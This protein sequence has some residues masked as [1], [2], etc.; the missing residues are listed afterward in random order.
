MKISRIKSWYGALILIITAVH[1]GGPTSVSSKR[2]VP[3][4]SVNS[5]FNNSN[6]EAKANAK[7]QQDPQLSLAPAAT[8]GYTESIKPYLD[9]TCV[10]CHRTGGLP[11]DLSSYSTAKAAAAVSLA[12]MN[13]GTM[14]P[15]S[16][17][18]ATTLEKATFAAWIAGGTPESIPTTQ[19]GTTK[20]PVPQS[21]AATATVCKTIVTS[22]SQAAGT[23]ASGV[24]TTNNSG[25]SPEPAPAPA[26]AKPAITYTANIKPYFDARCAGCHGRA[27]ALRTYANVQ[28]GAAASLAAMKRGSMPPGGGAPAQDIANLQ[29]WINAGYPQ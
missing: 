2:T 24:P 4:D 29:A 22:P 20:S 19:S 1:C 5:D 9:D 26:P 12:S 10:G 6:L 27:P 21:P 28:A 13:K 3:T 17:S 11:P 25:N 16:A 23:Q 15:G 14:P 18:G 7:C 8:V